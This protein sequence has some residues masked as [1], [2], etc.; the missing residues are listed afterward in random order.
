MPAMRRVAP[1]RGL[2]AVGAVAEPSQK[3]VPDSDRFK[4]AVDQC[5]V[6]LRKQFDGQ[7]VDGYRFDA[8]VIPLTDRV[9]YLG[10]E[11]HVYFFYKC[12]ALKGEPLEERKR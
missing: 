5:V 9:R 11:R 2:L 3:L 8:Y 7:N 4:Q 1:A 10:T 12:M 6:E